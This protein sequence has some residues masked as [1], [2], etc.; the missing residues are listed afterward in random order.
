VI[1]K[2]LASIVL[3]VMASVYLLTP[4]LTGDLD[5]THL[6]AYSQ[7]FD[8]LSDFKKDLDIYTISWAARHY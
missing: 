4:L 3:I 8:D 5:D 6:S 1:K 7:D 2:V